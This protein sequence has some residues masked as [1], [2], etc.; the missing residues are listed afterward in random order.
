MI[1]RLDGVSKSHRRPGDGRKIALDEVSLEVGRGQLV[2]V[3]GQSGS[4]KTTLLRIAAGL[5]AA[6]SGAASYCGERFDCMSRKQRWQVRRREIACVWAKQLWDDGLSVQSH[7][8]MPLL[9]DGCGHRAARERAEATLLICEAEQ[10]AEMEVADLSDG[11]RQRVAIARALVIEP[12]LLLADAPAAHLSLAEQEQ[13]MRLLSATAQEGKV[14]VLVTDSN[15][16]MLGADA[17]HYLSEGKLVA[18]EP[19]AE[20]G[21]IYRFPP[22]R[23]RSAAADA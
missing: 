17:V 14:A 21:R 4:G 3:F 18:P 7:V 15:E 16:T 11:E 19:V 2:G 8:E 12:R 1:L 22:A 13:V 6:D 5:L 9:V 10:C 23:S 20:L